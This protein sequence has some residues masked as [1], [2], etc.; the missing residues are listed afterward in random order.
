MDLSFQALEQRIR[1]LEQQFAALQQAGAASAPPPA[2][3]TT[4][5]APVQI[6]DQTGRLLLAIEQR[7]H[8]L[9]I[10]L[11]NQD[12]KVAATDSAMTYPTHTCTPL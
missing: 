3:P 10:R 4:L 9:S 5:V 11:F 8:D 7:Q 1:E 6:V 12:G 2:G